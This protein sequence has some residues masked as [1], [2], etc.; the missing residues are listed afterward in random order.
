MKDILII[1]ETKTGLSLDICNTM[2]TVA[3]ESGVGLRRPIETAW[4]LSGPKCFEIASKLYEI[5]S[6]KNFSVAVFEIESVLFAPA[7]QGDG[8]TSQQMVDMMVG[9]DLA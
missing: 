4:L 2:T 9:M 1:V 7:N 3:K 6:R 8:Q 5:A